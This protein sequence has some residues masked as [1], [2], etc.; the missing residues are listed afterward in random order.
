[1]KH[2][3]QIWMPSYQNSPILGPFYN[4][5]LTERFPC[6]ILS[7]VQVLKMLDIIENMVIMELTDIPV[8]FEKIG[9]SK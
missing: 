7:I 2:F 8:L 9:V 3:L 5:L 6:T 1:M 4:F